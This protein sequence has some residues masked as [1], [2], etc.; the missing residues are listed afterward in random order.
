M[1][2][3]TSRLQGGFYTTHIIFTLNLILCDYLIARRRVPLDDDDDTFERQ[4]LMENDEK[5][6]DFNFLSFFLLKNYKLHLISTYLVAFCY[7]LT[8]KI[9]IFLILSDSP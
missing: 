2:I 1:E 8:T 6:Y 4:P 3:T 9:V 7:F 5:M